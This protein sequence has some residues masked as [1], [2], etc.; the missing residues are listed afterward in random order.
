MNRSERTF[1]VAAEVTV[2][3]NGGSEERLEVW[4]GISKA[5]R[6]E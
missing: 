5:S 2:K 3:P 4:R 1:D 6:F